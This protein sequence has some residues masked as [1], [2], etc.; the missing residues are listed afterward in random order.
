MKPAKAILVASMAIS[1]AGCM[2]RGSPKKVYAAPATPKPA[3]AAPAPPPPALSIPQTQAE[4]PPP[5]PLSAEALATTLPPEEGPAPA[6]PA[7][8]K[9]VR[10]ASQAPR[11]DPPTQQATVPVPPPEPERPPVQELVS[12]DEQKQLLAD[13]QRDRQDARHRLEQAAAR[14][15]NRQQQGWK[16]N[17]ESLLTLSEDA[18]KRGDL[19]QARELAGRASVLA[20]ELQP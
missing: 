15:L 16:K 20:K 11:V 3:V 4:L 13:A 7:A 10:R 9:P 6:T 19:R 2:L 1:L 18:E 14:H 17:I 5:Q 8:P 12:A